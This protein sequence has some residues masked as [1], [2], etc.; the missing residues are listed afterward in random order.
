MPQRPAKMASK[1]EEPAVSVIMPCFNSED[2]IIEAM[3]SVLSQAPVTGIVIDDGSS[4]ATTKQVNSFSDQRIRLI[5]LGAI[6][7]LPMLGI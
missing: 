3:R 2:T 7:V 1:M 4:D 6:E 5:E